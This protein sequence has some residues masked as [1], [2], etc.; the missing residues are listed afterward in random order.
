MGGSP[1]AVRRA[2]HIEIAK[3]G[4]SKGGHRRMREGQFHDEIKRSVGRIAVQACA[5]VDGAPITAL[6]IE[7]SAVR[8]SQVLWDFGKY[9]RRSDSTPPYIE[10]SRIDS[11]LVRMREQNFVA[12]ASPGK[13]IVEQRKIIL[14]D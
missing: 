4:S 10:W 11:L 6:F 1:L 14:R 3:S 12:F 9:A 8:N 5:A 7:G 2:R 13:A